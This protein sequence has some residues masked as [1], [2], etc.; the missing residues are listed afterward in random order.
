MPARDG[1]GPV[2]TGP[3]GRRGRANG[4]CVG[5]DNSFNDYGPGYGGGYGMRFGRGGGFRA[6]RRVFA[7]Y[8]NAPEQYQAEPVPDTTNRE[9]EQQALKQE[10]HEL[11]N[12]I[13]ELRQA[14]TQK[15]DK[16]T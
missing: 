5:P 7:N 13:N 1:S 12:E 14:M 2:G 15:P 4:G 11:K 8:Y 9:Q 6:R 16:E 10:I 3:I